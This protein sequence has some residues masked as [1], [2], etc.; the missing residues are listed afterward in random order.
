MLLE[1]FLSDVP[2]DFEGRG[3]QVVVNGEQVCGEVHL[4]DFLEAGKVV[5][6]RLRVP[7][8]EYP[9]FEVLVFYGFL[10]RNALL[11]G[12]MPQLAEI[13]H[14]YGDDEVLKGVSIDKDLLNDCALRVNVLEFLGCDVLSLG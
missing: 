1:H 2:L 5:L 12:E 9:S 8:L 4:L 10:L 13:R 14:N 11:L 6:P 3:D 7:F